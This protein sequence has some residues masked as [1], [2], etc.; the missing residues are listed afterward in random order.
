MSAHRPARSIGSVH[1]P[2]TIV[3]Y[4]APASAPKRSVDMAPPTA[5]VFTRAPNA[6]PGPTNEAVRGEATF[7]AHVKRQPLC[8]AKAPPPP[9]SPW[10]ARSRSSRATM[11][12]STGSRDQ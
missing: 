9:V 3:V 7:I 4:Q 10:H 5:A 1:K 2:A 6:R 12:G 11:G 8:L